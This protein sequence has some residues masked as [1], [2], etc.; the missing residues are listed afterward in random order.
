MNNVKSRKGFTLVE[1]SIAM[2]FIAILLILVL[3]VIINITGMHARGRT[4]R[5]VN[6]TGRAII[7]DMRRTL[8]DSP[9][10]NPNADNNIVHFPIGNSNPAYKTGGR[11]CTGTYTYVWN[12]FRGSRPNR[13]SDNNRPFSVAKVRDPNRE[14]CANLGTGTDQGTV[15]PASEAVELVSGDEL[16]IYDFAAF[17]IH[18]RASGQTLYSVSF[19]LGTRDGI[20]ITTNTRCIQPGELDANINFC[21]INRF[22]FTARS[23]R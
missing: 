19:V 1:L 10:F 6:D 16:V 11:F 12:T 3:V 13:Y 9:P 5:D 17:Q 21:A 8:S 2:A 20:D 15:G 23:V 7:N 4:L 14:L 18:S 22:D